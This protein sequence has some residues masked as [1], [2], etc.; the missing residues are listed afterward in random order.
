MMLSVISEIINRIFIDTLIS[1]LANRIDPSIITRNP[2][3]ILFI[4][5]FLSVKKATLKHTIGLRYCCKAPTLAA[6]ISSNNITSDA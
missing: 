5:P 6:F 3:R 2:I 1:P 4:L